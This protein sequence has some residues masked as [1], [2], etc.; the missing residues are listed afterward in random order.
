M[1]DDPDRCY[2]TSVYLTAQGD[3]A[4]MYRKI[5]L[6][7]VSIPD[8]PQ[9]ME[10]RQT[11]LGDK[12]V[13]VQSPIGTLGLTVCYDVRFP[14][15]YQRLVQMGAVALT[16]PLSVYRNHRRSSLACAAARPRD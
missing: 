1:P 11:A 13:C 12:A 5:H 8:G 2:N 7:D 3:I 6:F 14:A 15:L 9:L 4:A 16:V 10:S